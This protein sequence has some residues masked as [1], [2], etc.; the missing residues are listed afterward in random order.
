[1][2]RR[3]FLGTVGGLAA[4]GGCVSGNPEDDQS[5]DASDGP[6]EESG[7]ETVRDHFDGEPERPE[8]TNVY[9]GDHA[10]S[11]DEPAETIPYPDPPTKYTTDALVEYVAAFEEA[12]ITHATLCDRSGD[13]VILRVQN[14]ITDRETFDWHKDI[15]IVG[16]QRYAGATRGFDESGK[17]WQATYSPTTACYAIDDTGV[18]RVHTEHHSPDEYASDGPNPVDAGTLVHTFG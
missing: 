3:T 13:D 1:M 4:L 15:T 11:V 6:G 7:I 17:E 8:C 10:T 9:N 16:L 2:R 18:A 5:N 14:R 12:Y